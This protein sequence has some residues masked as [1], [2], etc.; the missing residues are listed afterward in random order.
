[1]M[2]TN[3]S[4]DLIDEYVKWIKDNTVLKTVSSGWTE[5]N[6]PFLDRHNDGIQIYVRKVGD[7]LELTD[8]GYT[9]S[10]LEMS[11]CELK[12]EK[13]KSF[14]E[15][16]INSNSIRNNG[17]TLSIS[18]LPEDFPARKTEFIT[19]LQ[20][21]GGLYLTSRSI[22]QSFFSD[23]VAL[24]LESKNKYP[25]RD[26]SVVGNNGVRYDIDFLFPKKDRD[27]SETVL[28]AIRDPDKNNVSFHALMRREIRKDLDIYLMLQDEGLGERKYKELSSIA[29]TNDL[30]IIRWSEKEDYIGMLA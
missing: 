5:I 14:L 22:V 30:G 29:K 28:Q 12:S 8:D 6:T 18:V 25:L 17:G 20:K 13:Q 24:W 9:L 27:S 19:A 21:I 1:M 26:Y 4:S 10:D 16:I 11:G 23:E 7:K 3:E 2:T 15:S